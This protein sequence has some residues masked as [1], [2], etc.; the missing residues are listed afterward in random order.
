ML[1]LVHHPA[2]EKSEVEAKLKEAMLL[3][4]H[5]FFFKSLMGFF[6]LLWPT[7]QLINTVSSMSNNVQVTVPLCRKKWRFIGQN[8]IMK[9]LTINFSVFY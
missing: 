2:T 6:V 9:A 5:F 8:A 7:F 1:L 4:L 3:I